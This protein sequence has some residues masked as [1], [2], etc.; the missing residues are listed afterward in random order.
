M[1]DA[2]V[3]E[4]LWQQYH[5]LVP[6]PTITSEPPP[7]PVVTKKVVALTPPAVVVVDKLAPFCKRTPRGRF[8]CLSTDKLNTATVRITKNKLS[9]DA[10]SIRSS[11]RINNTPIVIR[12]P[13]YHTTLP[14]QE[15]KP[16][17]TEHAIVVLFRLYVKMVAA[18]RPLFFK[19]NTAY[20]GHEFDIHHDKDTLLRRLAPV[21]SLDPAVKLRVSP[22]IVSHAHKTLALLKKSFQ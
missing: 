16:L 10:I 5:A 3:L 19:T 6:P 15:A 7:E 21:P 18:I 17:V 1:I 4:E 2:N 11:V 9:K 14:F 8:V 22:S 13:V 20:D 12:G